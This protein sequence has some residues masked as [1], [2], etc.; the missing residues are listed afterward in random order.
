MLMQLFSKPAKS[1]LGAMFTVMALGS[2]AIAD[3]TEIFFGQSKDAFNTNPNI[4]FILD[5]SGSMS[6][7]DDA[8]MSRMDRMKIA[9]RALLQES[10]SYNVGLMGFSGGKRGGSIHYPVGDLEQDSGNLCE[11]GICPD[12]RIVVKPEGGI[13]DASENDDTGVV[14]LNADRLVMADVISGESA[15]DENRSDDIAGSAYA[16]AVVAES[17]NADGTEN[18]RTITSSSNWFYNGTAGSSDDRYAYR[19]ED[20]DIPSGA[21]VTSAFITFSQTNPVLQAG[22]MSALI[23]AEAAANANPLPTAL[24]GFDSIAERLVS[25]TRGI[26][27]NNIA[28][29]TTTVGEK[30]IAV[31]AASDGTTDP[32]KSVTPDISE[33]L[34]LIVTLPEWQA[35]NA[36][37]LILDPVDEYTPSPADIRNMHGVD[38]AEPLRPVINFTYNTAVTTDLVTT[39]STATAHADEI[40]NPTTGDISS[41]LTNSESRLFFAATTHDPRQLAFRFDDIDIPPDAEIQ[42]A[43]LLLTP[44]VIASAESPLNEWSVV[45]SETNTGSDEPESTTSSTSTESVD[46]D[47]VSTPPTDGDDSVPPVVPGTLIPDNMVSININAETTGTPL[48]YEAAPLADRDFTTQF[49]PWEDI[50]FD[51][52]NS[53]TSPNLANVISAVV[54]TDTWSDG[55]SLS[56]LLS[57][58]TDYN[59][60]LVNSG[61]INTELGAHKPEL[62]IVWRPSTVIDTTI[63]NSQTTAIRFSNVHIPPRAIVKSARLVFTSSEASTDPVTLDISAERDNSSS[64]FKAEDFNL[65]GR[66][67]TAKKVSWIPEPWGLPNTKYYSDDFKDVVQE[68]IDLPEWCGGNPLTVFLAKTSGTDSRFAIAADANEVASPTLELTYAPGSVEPGAYCSNATVISSIGNSSGD[69]VEDMTTGIVDVNGSSLDTRNP[70]NNNPQLI[71]LRFPSLGVPKDTVI[72]NATLKLTL[73]KDITQAQAF[74]FSAIKTVDTPEFGQDENSI[75]NASRV[76][77]PTTVT[78]TVQPGVAEES[79]F[80]I[81]VQ[82]LVSAKVTDPDW[83]AGQPFVITAEAL[84][85]IAQSFAS[86]ETNEAYAPQLLVYYQSEK[87][88]PGTIYRDNLISIVDSMVAQ[89][90]TPIVGAYYEAAQYFTGNK[91]E[92]GLQRGNQSSDDRYHKVSHPSSYIDGVVD[93]P[94]TCTDA[95]QT[96]KSCRYEKILKKDGKDPTY[97]S[98]I[99][100]ECQQSHIILLSDG[101]ATSNS[102]KQLVRDLT[103]NTSCATLGAEACGVE[104]ATWLHDTDIATGLQGKQNI[105]THTIGFNLD[106]PEFLIDLADAG[107]GEFYE[108]DSASE[109]L[110]AFKNIFINVSKT[111]ISFVAP[112][113]TVSQSN[114]LKNREDIYYSL[115]KP[116]GTARWAGNLKRYKLGGKADENA[117]VLDVNDELAIDPETSRFFATAKSY[118][119]DVVDGDSVLLGGA[120][121]KLEMNGISHLARKAYIYT[122]H[123]T[124]LANNPDNEL[125]STNPKIQ[126][127]WLKLTSTLAADDDYVDNLLDWA[128]GKDIFDIDGDGDIE[129]ARAQMGDPMH[130][131]PLLVNY[132][133]DRGVVHVATN[134]GFLHAVDHNT[135]EEN[136]AF[137]PKELLPNLRRLYEDQVTTSRPYGLD[138]GLTLWIDDENNDG[139]VDP[140]TDKAYLYIGM[141]RGGNLYY[142]LDITDPDNPRY[143]WSILGGAN[144]ADIDD[145]T[146]DGNFTELGQTWSKPIKTKIY[147]DNAVRDVLIFGAGYGSNQDPIEDVVALDEAA[148]LTEDTRQTRTKDSVGRGFFIVDAKTGKQIWRTDPTFYPDLEYSVPSDIRVIDINFDGMADQFYFGDMG[149]QVWRFD[150][151]NDPAISV[152]VD[153]RMRGGRIARFGGDTPETSRRFYY[154]PDVALISV[155][156][157]QQLSISIGSGWRAHPLDTDTED[158]FYSF[159]MTQVFGAPTTEDGGI[160]YPEVTETTTGMIELSAD[161]DLRTTNKYEKG[162]FLPLDSAEKVLSSSVTVDGKLIFT[163]YIPSTDS[164]SC[165]ASI[166]SGAVYFLDLATGNPVKDLNTDESDSPAGKDALTAAD[167]RRLLPAAGI[168]PEATIL[169]PELG[170]ATAFAGRT[171]LD[172]VEIETLKTRTFWQEHIEENL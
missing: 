146:A 129:E 127:E 105:T 159:R 96:A 31:D 149:G 171:K 14:T 92:Y 55:Q 121:E 165:D 43:S 89:S 63:K 73:E 59:N 50:I 139:V 78:A 100:S 22:N 62:Q 136:F 150:Y 68:V 65:T 131:Q 52:G 91:V 145:T 56:L 160:R 116:E 16:V 18:T 152:N 77:Y 54:N 81:D 44:T 123:G 10:S 143:L 37:N 79:N 156:G 167:R 111:D 38:A 99:D 12:E 69:G 26:Q 23:K 24:N 170:K 60:L 125:I 8:G 13:N 95:N 104:L 30:L 21:V 154:A 86:F 137:F 158:R 155:D 103:G 46:A 39:V 147:D 166:G 163:S 157:E 4:L 132:A 72:V 148:D 88:R 34:N 11:D 110:N 75:S 161:G 41:N 124:E 135:G 29:D 58:P 102:A 109:L 83:I 2:V 27:W 128:R 142:A 140:L 51:P 101:L 7:W 74:K 107:G 47:S 42:S 48:P 84:G 25:A 113:A 53:M 70:T 57:A 15:G 61:L 164:D 122:G 97:I 64:P 49:E 19:F 3:D 1:L 82:P 119:S 169:F 40:I 134:E 133:G 144:T 141:R 76:P 6:R 93:R 108:A 172:E 112:S 35:G 20:I 36:F 120:S 33:I 168:P 87:E 45:A 66:Q 67:R 114:R 138:G 85:G 98:P 151:N 5:T 71:G 17:E 118:W 28:P 9:M 115:F 90:G 130:S 106:S 162:W 153:N 126:L 94:D 80:Q 32:T 117:D